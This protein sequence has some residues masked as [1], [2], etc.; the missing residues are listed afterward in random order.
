MGGWRYRAAVKGWTRIGGRVT[1]NR[2]SGPDPG[3]G[4]AVR[5][6][7]C[8]EL[9]ARP[10]RFCRLCGAPLPADQVAAAQ[11]VRKTVTCVFWDV[12]ESVALGERLDPEAIRRVMSVYV[13][14]MRR[15]VERHGGTV[16]KFIGDAAVL[17]VFGVPK[18]HEDD[19]LRAVR[20]AQEMSAALHHLN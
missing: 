20:A 6:D 7:R 17:A 1:L 2:H 10:A 15:V 3:S 12:V 11:E 9:T 13:E 4:A 5:C 8:Q 18:L 16:E 19:A 14:E